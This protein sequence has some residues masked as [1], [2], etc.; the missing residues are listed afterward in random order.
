MSDK[1]LMTAIKKRYRQLREEQGLK[2]IEFAQKYNLDR[3]Q[4]NNWESL[5]STRGVSIYTIHRFCKMIGKDV[6]YF[7]DST[8]FG[9]G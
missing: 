3:Q 7:F 2:Q 1:E 9:E 6:K 4:L 8:L 5:N